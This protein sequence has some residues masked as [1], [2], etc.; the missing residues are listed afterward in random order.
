M[1]VECRLRDTNSAFSNICKQTL[2]IKS[3]PASSPTPKPK[4][5]PTPKGK[6]LAL[7]DDSPTPTPTPRS[8]ATPPPT[9][10]VED[11]KP[12]SK[13]L[14]WIIPIIMGL[15]LIYLLYRYYKSTPPPIKY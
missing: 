6:V 10:D 7:V 1:N 8:F 3:Q 13:A 4:A 15:G 11:S 2:I 12:S 5:S 9:E 14:L